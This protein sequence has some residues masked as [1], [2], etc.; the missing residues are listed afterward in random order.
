MQIPHFA[1]PIFAAQRPVQPATVLPLQDPAK[2]Q[3][4]HGHKTQ[5]RKNDTRTPEKDQVSTE[6]DPDYVFVHNKDAEDFE[7]V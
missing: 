4:K 3:I 7:L 1:P 6:Q 2:K 5:K